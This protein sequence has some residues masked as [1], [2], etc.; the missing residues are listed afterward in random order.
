[1]WLR[2]QSR[3]VNIAAMNIRTDDTLAK[4]VD[5]EQTAPKEHSDQ[6]LHC[7]LDNIEHELI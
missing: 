2:R 4:S 5:P 7:L 3:Y 1:M 6:G